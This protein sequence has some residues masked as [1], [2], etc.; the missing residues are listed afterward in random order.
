LLLRGPTRT[1]ELN[2]VTGSIYQRYDQEAV[3]PMGSWADRSRADVLPSI[4]P[5]PG[6]ELDGSVLAFRDLVLVLLR[7][8]SADSHLHTEERLDV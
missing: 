2:P 7:G 3:L 1:L 5:E 8:H 4:I 6:Q